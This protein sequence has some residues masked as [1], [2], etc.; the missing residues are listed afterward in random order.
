VITPG[1]ADSNADIQRYT[2]Q[3]DY[4]HRPGKEIFGNRMP[5]ANSILISF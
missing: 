1:A 2:D 4:H 3:H 5:L